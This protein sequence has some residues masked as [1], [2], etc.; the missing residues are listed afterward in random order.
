VFRSNFLYF[1]IQYYSVTWQKSGNL[2]WKFF[3]YD[4]NQDPIRSFLPFLLDFLMSQ[5]LALI[6][7]V[8]GTLADTERDGHRVAFNRAFADAGLDWHWSVEHYGDLLEIAGGKERIQ[9]YVKT[10][11]PEFQ[12]SD[13]PDFA[14]TLH[15]AKTQHYQQLLQENIIPLRPGVKRLILEA[16]SQSFRLAI[17]TTSRLEN[18]L[19]LLAIALAPE[20][21]DWFE[22]IAAGD[23]VLHKK[24]A[25]DVYQYVLQQTQ[26]RPEDC[27]VFEDSYQGLQA[28]LGAGLKTV[29]TLND[30]T[31]DHDFTGASLV[32]SH[33]GEPDLPCQVIAGEMNTQYFCL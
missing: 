32:L 6:F 13:L 17:A 7:D 3:L 20:S 12:V 21:A 11:K 27:L 1:N 14:A 2:V 22:I 10:E 9:Y 8:D 16:R 28:A 4:A 26:L 15:A 30:Y 23:I 25:P 24:P 33:L 19:S 31:R 29:I 18:V 5:P